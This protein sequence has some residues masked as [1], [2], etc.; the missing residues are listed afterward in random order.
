MPEKQL[1]IDLTS[2]AT[3]FTDLRAVWIEEHNRLAKGVRWS[4]KWMWVLPVLTWAAF[5]HRGADPLPWLPV[6]GA[7]LAL[8]LFTLWMVQL[9]FTVLQFIEAQLAN[10][11]LH[12]LDIEE[13]QR[14]IEGGPKDR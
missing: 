9:L 10:Y 8:V 1:H 4:I 11:T 7:M 6:D 2:G 12:R 14:Q 5:A 13:A 3:S